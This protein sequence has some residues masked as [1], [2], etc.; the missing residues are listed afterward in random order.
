MEE[1]DDDDE[2]PVCNTS[3]ISTAIFSS[4]HLHLS[5]SVDVSTVLNG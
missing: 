4:D 5:L 1:D 2:V 3:I